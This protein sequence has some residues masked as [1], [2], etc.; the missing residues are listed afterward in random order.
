MKTSTWQV[1][2]AKNK[3]SELMDMAIAGEP[4]V[5]TRRGVEVVAVVNYKTFIGS[6]K[7]KKTFHQVMKQYARLDFPDIKH[8]DTVG[9]ATPFSF[10]DDK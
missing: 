2:T 5:I 4:Q 1:Q 3:L 6:N 10:E 9:R 7:P 8:D